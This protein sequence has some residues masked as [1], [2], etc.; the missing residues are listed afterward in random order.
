MLRRKEEAPGEDL[1]P[2]PAELPPLEGMD[3]QQNDTEESPGPW[4]WT[5]VPALAITLLVVLVMLLGIKGIYDGLKD[6]AIAN[7][8]MAQEH[9]A[10]GLVQLQAGDYELAIAEFELALEHDSSLPDLRGRLLEAKELAE[11]QVTPT[12]ETRRDAAVSLY[13]EAVAHYE[14]GN[15]AQA[16][17]ALD[18][19]RGIDASYQPENVNTMLATA[20]Y[21]LGLEAV[22][23]DR[24]GEA[25]FHFGAVLSLDTD[26]ATEQSA[27]EQINLLNLYSAALRHWDGDWSATIQA[28]KGLLSLAPDYKDVRQR[29]HDAY[30]YRGEGLVGEGDWCSASQDYDAALEVLPLEA[31]ADKR[32]DATVRCDDAA[33]SVVSATP[34]PA[35]GTRPTFGP[36]AAV[37]VTVASDPAPKPTTQAADFGAGRIA[38]PVY[39]AILKTHDVQ[40]VD[41]STGKSSVLRQNASQ[42]AFGPGGQH[43][44]FRNLDS[45]HLGIGILNLASGEMQDLTVHAEDSMPAWSSDARYIT[46]ASDKHGDRKWRVYA[47]SPGEVRGEGEMWIY[48]QMPAWSPSGDQIAYH[49]CDPQGNECGLWLMGP[50]G[51]NPAR[52]SSDASDTAPSWSPDGSQLVFTSARSG[53]WELYLVQA[54]GASGQ[55]EKLIAHPAADVAPTWSP[56]G[57]SVAFL[58]DRGGSWAVYVL[59]IKSGQAT[60]V[61]STG[62]GYPDPVGQR[63]S[64]GP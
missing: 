9:Y 40:V 17:V 29:L 35:A 12:S 45:G 32:D 54:A 34:K 21:Q 61:A 58:S 16:V 49:G 26:A 31:T 52:L 27:Q 15:L 47:I 38:F 50:G 22:S 19:L 8:E 48:G 55:E 23:D 44:S 33:A 36:T 62:D 37:V 56:D 59:D 1:V 63:L 24:L 3:E 13:K 11:A 10:A 2:V 25:Q 43:L 41:L 39:D 28:L 57:K 20:H 42:P 14:S 64:W 53:N 46:F 30:V 51:F 18:D 6:R 60:K 7:H 5:L 4:V